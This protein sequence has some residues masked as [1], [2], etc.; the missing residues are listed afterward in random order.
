MTGEERRGE[1]RRVEERSEEKRRGVTRLHG[2][3][4]PTIHA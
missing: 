2:W 4:P 1:E 3:L